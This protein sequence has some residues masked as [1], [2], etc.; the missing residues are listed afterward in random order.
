MHK[1]RFLPALA[2][3]LSQ[4]DIS[5]IKDLENELLKLGDKFKPLGSA[6]TQSA[7]SGQVGRP[8]LSDDQKSPKTIANEESLDSQGG[9]E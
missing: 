8:S 1:H 9:S 7:N 6:Y 3:G 4:R 2:L 5:N